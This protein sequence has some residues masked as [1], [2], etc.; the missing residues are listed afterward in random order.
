MAQIKIVLWNIQNFGG[1]NQDDYRGT[2]NQLLANVIRD[3]VRYEN[4]DILMII[5]VF[6]SALPALQALK[7]T[8][9]QGLV[10]PN[11]DWVF[12]WIKGSILNGSPNPPTTDAQ[13]DWKGGPTAPRTE[14]Y[15]IFWRTNRGSFKMIEA[16]NNVSRGGGV[17]PPPPGTKHYLEL[18]TEGLNLNY[19]DDQ[20]YSVDEAYNPAASQ[21]VP[22]DDTGALTTWKK[23]NFPWVSVATFAQPREDESRRPAFAILELNN[24][25]P[26]EAD[27]IL[28][29]IFY[30]APSN[31]VRAEMGTF[32]SALSKQI[33]VS[34]QLNGTKQKPGPANLTRVNQSIIGGDFNWRRTDPPD[35]VYQMFMKPYQSD[36]QGGSNMSFAGGPVI[37]S[38]TVQ[39]REL[40]NG[41]FSGDQITGTS[42]ADYMMLPID[43]FL[44]RGLSQVMVSSGRYDFLSALRASPP[45]FA[46]S[47]GEYY[48]HFQQMI[49][50]SA[51]VPEN[52]IGPLTGPVGLPVFGFRFNNW[53]EFYTDVKRPRS[54][55]RFTS[56]RSAAEFYHI[57]ISDHLP[58]RLV[59][60]TP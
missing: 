22:L 35:F 14:G 33:N 49:A 24:G 42:N 59:I 53:R 37:E 19:V 28:P 23:L 50:G 48:Q 3:F 17:Q 29:L 12:D 41:F 26:N 10:A 56:A 5:E 18:I 20:N 52:D 31:R 47:L 7:T 40:K 16:V 44:Y 8:L 60:N 43:Q 27:R 21:T 57:F 38:T 25:A 11:N 32:S 54:T 34:Q 58:L 55:R 45:R 36:L 30:H 13:L 6:P 15:A 46:A 1:A 9:N 39:T 51:W 2:N 4:I